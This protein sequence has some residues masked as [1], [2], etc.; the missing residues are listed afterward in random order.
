V[1]PASAVCQAEVVKSP[2]KT[3]GV[4]EA[5]SEYLVL[6]S[7]I[8]PKSISSTWAMFRGSRI[9]RQQLLTTDGVMGFA[10]LAEPLR[11]NYATLSVW[12]DDEALNAFAGAHPH[13]RLMAELAPSMNAPRFVRWTISGSDGIPSWAEAL[14]RLQ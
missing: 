5:D 10:L 8:P 11:K 4:L 13:A 2:W 14:E 7:S 1:D 6:A 9:V 12:R 3:L